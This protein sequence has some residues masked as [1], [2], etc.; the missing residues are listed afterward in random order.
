LE[1]T[2]E[3]VSTLPSL[4]LEILVSIKIPFLPKIFSLLPENEPDF[5]PKEGTLSAKKSPNST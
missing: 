5:T 3:D 1:K 4:Y 2:S